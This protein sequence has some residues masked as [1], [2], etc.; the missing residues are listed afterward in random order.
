MNLP[1]LQ[2]RW[3]STFPALDK[4]LRNY[5]ALINLLAEYVEEK[6]GKWKKAEKLMKRLLN[7]ETFMGFR[8]LYNMAGTLYQLSLRHQERGLTF[9]AGMKAAQ[10]HMMGL[11]VC[12]IQ[13]IAR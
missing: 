5:G 4:L 8:F 2:T 7:F 13:S 11:S 10:V 1:S 3:L 9:E 6:K 12:N